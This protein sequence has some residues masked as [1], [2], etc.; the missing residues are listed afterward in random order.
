MWGLLVMSSATQKLIC[1]EKSNLKRGK[2]CYLVFHVRQKSRIVLDGS[3]RDS[4]FLFHDLSAM[5]KNPSYD[6]THCRCTNYSSCTTHSFSRNFWALLWKPNQWSKDTIT[7]SL[8]FSAGL[9]YAARTPEL[10]HFLL[11][12]LPT[13]LYN[14]RILFWQDGREQGRSMSSTCCSFASPSSRL[15]CPLVPFST[16]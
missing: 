16:G 11:P 4:I 1:K 8:S 13:L 15:L 7:Q 10:F 6:H 2:K 5:P 3:Q 14:V 9:L 12:K